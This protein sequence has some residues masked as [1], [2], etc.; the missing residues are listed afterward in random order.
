MQLT[1]NWIVTRPLSKSAGLNAQTQSR[2]QPRTR[3]P[4][5]STYLLLMRRSDLAN[6]MG[7]SG[8]RVVWARE[9]ETSSRASWMG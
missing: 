1:K 7:A 2:Q 4:A 3:H 8:L 6:F 9:R 5:P